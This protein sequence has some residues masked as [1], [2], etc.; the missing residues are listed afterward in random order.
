VSSVLRSPCDEAAALA[1]APD[2]RAFGA[3]RWV[4]AVSILGSSIAF[5]DGTVVNVALPALQSSLGATLRE[6]QWV[7]EAYALFLAALLLVGGALGDR[8]SRRKVFAAGVVLFALASAWCG[9]APNVSHLVAARAVQGVGG[10]L[11]VPGSLALI[12]A[13]FPEDE[14]GRAIGTWSAFTSMTAALGP[15]LGGWLVQNL[16]WRWA[17]FLN[18]PIAAVVVA[19]TL[20]RVPECRPGEAAAGRPDALGAALAALGLGGIVWALIESSP[21]AAALGAAAL[22][23]F[24]AVEARA[25]SPMLPLTVFRSRTFTL[26]NLFTLFLYAALAG[27]LFFF[28]L[29]LI[30]VQGYTATEA[31]AALLPFIL[32]LFLLSRWSG[33][34]VARHGPRPPLVAGPLVSAAGFALFARPGIGGSYWTTFFP[35]VVVLGLGMAVTVAPLTTAVMGALPRARAGVASGVNNAVSRVAALLAVAVFGFVLGRVFDRSLDGALAAG[36]VPAA[37]RAEI[38]AQR[39][40]LAAADVADPRGKRAVA[41]AFVAGFRVVALLAAALAVASAATALA[42]RKE[43][44]PGGRGLES[45]R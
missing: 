33:G 44:P 19:L 16:S 28:P 35:A 41:E 15:V 37:A 27:L 14:R 11:L 45:P 6:V 43:T 2:G 26:A 20:L 23:A 12:S 40:K 39:E 25:A 24:V 42:L 7:V 34:L 4:L 18:L 9:L 31:G 10:A 38:D 8:L 3:G 36:R 22:A 32:L 5:I 21:P 13:S 29:D 1:G 30:Q 17:F